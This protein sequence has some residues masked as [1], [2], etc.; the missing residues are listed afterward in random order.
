MTSRKSVVGDRSQ[1]G[2]GEAPVEEALV[3]YAA[4]VHAGSRQPLE[5]ADARVVPLVLGVT[6]DAQMRTA[7]DAVKSL[8]LL[9]N[10]AGQALHDDDLTCWSA[11]SP[12]TNSGPSTSPGRCC[13]H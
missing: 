3:R 4:R 7:A 2:I 8:D 9:A 12:S 6:D 10:N 1:P 5:H 11:T 13:L